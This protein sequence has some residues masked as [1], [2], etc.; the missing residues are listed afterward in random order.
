MNYLAALVRIVI[1]VYG[2]NLACMATNIVIAC[3]HGRAGQ[4]LFLDNAGTIGREI[5]TGEQ[6]SR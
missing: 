4:Y 5:T 2:I 6:W 3:V 1:N